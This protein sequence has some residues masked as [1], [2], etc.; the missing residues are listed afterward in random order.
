MPP[1]MDEHTGARIARAR[2]ARRLTQR[3]LTDL[4]HVSYSTP[5]ELWDAYRLAYAGGDR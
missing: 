2:K 4:S 5:T 1:H 3:E